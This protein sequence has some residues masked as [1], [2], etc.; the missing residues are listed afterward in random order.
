MARLARIPALR[1]L[2]RAGAA[3]LVGLALASPVGGTEPS[4][5]DA[6]GDPS[7]R[8]E[9]PDRAAEPW[10]TGWTIGLDNDVLVGSGIDR[11]Y[12]AG[13]TLT[14]GGRRVSGQRFSLDP[15]LGW[16]DRLS[17]FEG[18]YRQQ[19]SAEPWHLLQFGLQLF[20]PRDVSAVE[21]IRDDRPYANLVYVATS[22]YALNLR[23]DRVYQ[24][25][26]TLGLLGTGFGEAVQNAV[27]DLS[28][29]EPTRG[30][31]N[32]VSDG[33]EPTFRYTVGRQALLA[34]GGA[35]RFGHYDLKTTVGG[36]LGYLT[37][38]GAGLSLRL[39][40]I[41]SPWWRTAGESAHYAAQPALIASPGSGVGGSSE[42]YLS[43][44]LQAR[45]RAY[46]A[47]LQGQFRDSAVTLSFGELNPVLFD[48][49]L[50]YAARLGGV[51]I[52]YSIRYQSPEIRSGAASRDLVWGGLTIGGSFR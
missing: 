11:D 19:A 24:S 15:A 1:H 18:R 3:G 38:A 31:H 43:L 51:D 50:G 17:G 46:N 45:L 52:Q 9:A 48:V 32:Q 37:E 4:T 29:S 41:Q 36:S 21:P 22:R 20:T 33:G 40:R 10:T 44:G 25:T 47:L 2:A 6:S 28:G 39:G 27:H 42:S 8:R 14:M 49:W 23:R 13:A 34:S 16:F 30:F 12:T 26:L 35:G 7:A 5:R